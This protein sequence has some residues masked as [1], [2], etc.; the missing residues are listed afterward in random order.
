MVIK[1]MVSIVALFA[2]ALVVKAGDNV[3]SNDIIVDGQ[4][5]VREVCS[6]NNGVLVLLKRCEMSY[7]NEGR[8]VNK[9]DYKWNSELEEWTFVRS[10]DYSYQDGTYTITLT[11]SK[12]KTTTLDYTSSN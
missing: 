6:S 11:D 3:F 2:S 8:I 7:D 1:A 5:V 12:G 10:Y 9:R 4:V